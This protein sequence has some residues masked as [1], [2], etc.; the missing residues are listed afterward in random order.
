MNLN[1]IA[2][3]THRNILVCIAA[4]TCL[5][6]TQQAQAE[7]V[8]VSDDF[9]S[10]SVNT[11]GLTFSDLSTS[12]AVASGAW[13]ATG[14]TNWTISGGSLTNAGG[15]SNAQN[16]GAFSRLVD[17]SSITD[18]SLNQLKLD[19]DFTTANTSENLFVHMRGFI[20]GT[21]P[22]GTLSIVNGNATNG[23]AWNNAFSHADWT[24]YN[25]NSGQLNNHAS[26]FSS[27]GFAVQLTDGVA[28][29]HS[30]NQTFDM[31]GYAAAADDIAGFDYLGVF[32]TRNHTGTSPSVS[33][34]NFTLS[35]VPEPTTFAMFGLA[36][37]G[38]GFRRRR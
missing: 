14:G 31:S 2:S 17:I 33:I 13:E 34:S 15:G 38:L 19:V 30:F 24:I 10:S 28:G 37:A 9:S 1:S 36:M 4:I 29:A 23:N 7:I 21:D 6:A 5:T 25:L 16:E 35:V 3:K 12:G 11:N 26:N 20:L 8:L 18:T 27:A 22:A 32:V